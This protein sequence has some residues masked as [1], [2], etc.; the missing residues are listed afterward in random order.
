MWGY[1]QDLGFLRGRI[2]LQPDFLPDLV[3]W[4]P[5]PILEN[6]DFL[7]YKKVSSVLTGGIVSGFG[8]RRRNMECTSVHIT[9]AS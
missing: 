7:F 1:Q 4:L 2:P 5:V 3:I 9:Q 8:F 6:L